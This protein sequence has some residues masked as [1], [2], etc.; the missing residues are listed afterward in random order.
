[1]DVA[2]GRAEVGRVELIDVDRDDPGEV[3]R[4]R[5]R[6]EAEELIDR[7]AAAHRRRIA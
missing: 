4:E 1:M 3:A 5:D 6:A 2:L 7:V